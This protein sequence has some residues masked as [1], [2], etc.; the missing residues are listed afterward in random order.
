[1]LRT[2]D[3]LRLEVHIQD[4]GTDDI[5]GQVGYERLQGKG[6]ARVGKVIEVL[7]E[8]FDPLQNKRQDFPEMLGG[9]ARGVAPAQMLPIRA[10]IDIIVSICL[11]L[12]WIDDRSKRAYFSAE[13]R[14]LA[15]NGNHLSPSWRLG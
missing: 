8:R 13:D 4:R 11:A 2:I 3:E 12:G 9:E 5:K 14:G 6:L 1:M 15:D 7:E 10:L